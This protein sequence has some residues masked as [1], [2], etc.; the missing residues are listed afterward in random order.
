VKTKQEM[1]DNL[2]EIHNA[3]SKGRDELEELADECIT[4]LEISQDAIDNIQTAIDRL[5]E[6]V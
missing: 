2:K 3:L 5:S 4:Y 6:L 1:L